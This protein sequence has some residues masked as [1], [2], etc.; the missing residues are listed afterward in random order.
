MICP[1]CKTEIPDKASKCPHCTQSLVFFNHPTISSIILGF[2]IIGFS[3]WTIWFP[4]LAIT[5]FVIG[6]LFV[7][8]G[9]LTIFTGPLNKL[10]QSQKEKKEHKPL[11]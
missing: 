3:V 6:A 4:P 1:Y 11:L 9:I 8:I 2:S 7:V 10:A 5:L